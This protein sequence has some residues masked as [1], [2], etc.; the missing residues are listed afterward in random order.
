MPEEK[1]AS[2]SVW[3]KLTHRHYRLVVLD[4]E[5]LETVSTFKLTLFN[6]YVLLSSLLVAFAFMVVMLIIFTPLKTYIPGFTGSGDGTVY[7]LGQRVNQLEKELAAN[8]RY[9]KDFKK[10]LLGDAQTQKDFPNVVVVDSL[11]QYPIDESGHDDHDH[12]D[13]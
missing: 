13:F 6:V 7:K 4:H 11:A 3:W 1:N 10:M 12:G 5:T 8:E 9:H 2:N